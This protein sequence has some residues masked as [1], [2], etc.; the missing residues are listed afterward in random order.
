MTY[1]YLSVSIV[2][3]KTRSLNCEIQNELIILTARKVKETAVT[4]MSFHIV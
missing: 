2:K 1:C 3:M 4:Q